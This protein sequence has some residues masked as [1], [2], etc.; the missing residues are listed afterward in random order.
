MRKQE[1]LLFMLVGII[2]LGGCLGHCET[3][4][5]MV[6]PVVILVFELA[7]ELGSG[8]SAH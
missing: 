6:R 4:T 8:V 2:A 5:I 7:Y 1:I 3:L